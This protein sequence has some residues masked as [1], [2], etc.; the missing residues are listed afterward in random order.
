MK[1]CLIIGN[2]VAREEEI[3]KKIVIHAIELDCYLKISSRGSFT[4]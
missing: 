2:G 4:V 1:R 3:Y